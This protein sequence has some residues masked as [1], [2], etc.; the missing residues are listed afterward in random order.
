MNLTTGTIKTLVV[1]F[2]CNG[3]LKVQNNFLCTVK[4]I[5]QQ[6]VS[7]WNSR[8]LSLEGRIINFKTFAIS[9]IFYLV[10]LTVIPNSLIEEL[11][12]LQK[13]FIWHCSH[14]NI[15]HKTLCS[16]FEN[17]GLKHV[18]ISSKSLNL[19]CS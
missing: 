5:M 8:M 9:K 7:F 16:N 4:S 2:S 14:P 11:Q 3:A 15:S 18:N 17:G 10:F 13:S 19:Q 6:V 1:H 12:K